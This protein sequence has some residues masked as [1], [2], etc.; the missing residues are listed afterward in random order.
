MTGQR[1]GL[2]HL[3]VLL[4]GFASIGSGKGHHL[5]LSMVGLCRHG[6]AVPDRLLDVTPRGH[7][8]LLA[9]VQAVSPSGFMA[10]PCTM[11][12]PDPARYISSPFPLRLITFIIDG[13]RLLR[14]TGTFRTPTH[15]GD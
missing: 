4:P 1:L 6:V 11:A 3:T 9:P 14:E 10:E 8:A 2:Q 7:L 13:L 15:H 5:S 12:H